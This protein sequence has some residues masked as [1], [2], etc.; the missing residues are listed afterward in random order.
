MPAGHDPDCRA[1][2][3]VEEA[4]GRNNYFTKGEIWKFR[5]EAAGLRKFR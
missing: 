1:L 2:A 4:I 3:T 5:N